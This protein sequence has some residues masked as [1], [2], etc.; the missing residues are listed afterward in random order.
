[1][2][3]APTP[4]G[5]DRTSPGSVSDLV[6]RWYRSPDFNKAGES[7]RVVTRRIIEHFRA[8]FGD[9]RVEDFT[10][11]H[12]DALLV[13]AARKSRD[14]KGRLVGGPEAA[15]RL[16]KHLSRLFR[17]AVKIR[18]IAANP[19]DHAEP[20]AKPKSQGFHTWTE[21]EIAAFQRRHPLGTKPRLALEIMLWTAQRG[22]DAR[23][24]GAKHERGGRVNFRAGKT[25]KDMWLPLAPQLRAAIAAMPALGLDAYLITAY[26]QPFSAKGFGQWFRDQ[27]DAAGLPHCTAHGLRK[28]AARRAAQLGG[29][30]QGLK[31]LGGW[32]GDREVATYTAA[33]DQASLANDTLGRVIDWDL[34]NRAT[35]DLASRSENDE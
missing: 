31:A 7:T 21:E 5:A 17:H 14:A 2:A 35:R 28:A 3:A 4:A 32:S 10:F 30:N 8:K 13:R 15:A 33:V 29:T 12:I 24:F 16:R 1:M 26:G 34:A 27:C 19:V 22:G 20:V 23:L 18:M 25:G 11:E 6:I 9:Q